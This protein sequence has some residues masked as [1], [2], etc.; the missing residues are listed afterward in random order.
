MNFGVNPR[1]LCCMGAKMAIPSNRLNKMAIPSN[2]LIYIFINPTV[3]ESVA[4]LCSTV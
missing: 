4:L 3:N 2:R 1:N